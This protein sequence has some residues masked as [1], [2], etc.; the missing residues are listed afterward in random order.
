MCIR[1]R[2]NGYTY[3]WKEEANRTE[4]MQYGILAQEIKESYP[5]LVTTDGEG[6]YAVNYSGLVPILL[7][8]LKEERQ[9]RKDDLKS[10]QNELT[11]LRAMLTESMNTKEAEPI[12][13]KAQ[14]TITEDNPFDLS[15]LKVYPN[16]TKGKLFLEINT[17]EKVQYQI[18][19]LNGTILSTVNTYDDEGISI[20]NLASGI[21]LINVQV[22]GEVQTIKIIKE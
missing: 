8:A 13:G 5:E 2:I 12:K 11:E 10:L 18:T 15:S 14:L 4:E 9:E 22:E 3:Q 19:S 21:Y 17:D 7:Q 20:E 1:D 6:Y 16:P